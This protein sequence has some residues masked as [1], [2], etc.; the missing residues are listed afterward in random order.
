MDSNKDPWIKINSET[1]LECIVGNKSG[2]I[3]LKELIQSAIDNKGV[4]VNP[5]IKSD[6]KVVVCTEEE[7]EETESNPLP[8]WQNLLFYSALVAWL[9]ILPIVGIIMLVRLWLA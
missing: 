8:K 9:G 3:K 7:F 2:F 1:Y 4:D 6:F 5:H